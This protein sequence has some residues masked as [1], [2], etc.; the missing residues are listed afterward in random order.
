[1]CRDL[2]AAGRHCFAQCQGSRRLELRAP[3]IETKVVLDQVL[4]DQFE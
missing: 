3:T 4:R 2:F 1:L